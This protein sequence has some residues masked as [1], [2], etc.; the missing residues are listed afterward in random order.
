M[1][2]PYGVRVNTV[3]PGA[4]LNPE[5]LGADEEFVKKTNEKIPLGRFGKPEEIT[6]AVIFLASDA[7]S[8]VTG[9]EIVIDG[10]WTA[11]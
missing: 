7:A 4:F 11:W 3:V 5:R 2:A 8:F 10:G 9:T 1:W 6:G